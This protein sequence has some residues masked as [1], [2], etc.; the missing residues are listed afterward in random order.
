LASDITCLDSPVLSGVATVDRWLAT[1]TTA[2][3]VTDTY[4]IMCKNDVNN[5]V[6]SMVPI[7]VTRPA[8]KQYPLVTMTISKACPSGAS[9][10][11][12]APNN[13][14]ELV[15]ITRYL[16]NKDGTE[17][18]FGTNTGTFSF[19]ILTQDSLL[20]TIVPDIYV[21]Y[22]SMSGVSDARVG[23]LSWTTS[24]GTWQSVY[25][26]Q[27]STTSTSS[28]WT[29]PISIT[30]TDGTN[31]KIRISGS[32]S[33]L[34]S[35]CPLGGS[36]VIK[37]AHTPGGLFVDI[38]TSST[39][40]IES[41]GSVVFTDTSCTDCFTP[42]VTLQPPQFA[43]G[44]TPSATKWILSTAAQASSQYDYYFS[45][46]SSSAESTK[47]KVTFAKTDI[48]KKQHPR[49]SFTLS[50]PCTQG[51]KVTIYRKSLTS[52][53]ID[54]VDLA[55]LYNDDGTQFQIQGT[56]TF[57]F[58]HI[59]D[60][61]SLDIPIYAFWQY[62]L[63]QGTV[64]PYSRTS[65][66]KGTD[67]GI[68]TGALDWTLPGYKGDWA[69]TYQFRCTMG[70]TPIGTPRTFY[71]TKNGYGSPK[72]RIVGS[73]TDYN[74]KACPVGKLTVLRAKG[75]RT[76]VA[77]PGGTS[78]LPP[79]PPSGGSP[80]VGSSTIGFQDITS[81]GTNFGGRAFDNDLI[82]VDKA[83]TNAPY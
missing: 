55:Q 82:F 16:K 46:K 58:W 12:Y 63:D 24:S 8:Q 28:A 3:E 7:T 10:K 22:N 35:P 64:N 79:L 59:D 27:C 62:M 48:T 34:S 40:T 71:I 25:Q 20:S 70:S 47:V 1:S 5:L 30:K 81:Q 66:P 13:N 72:I 32:Q 17:F 41:D 61:G 29:A 14:Q 83:I 49:I 36:L 23:D 50:A 44:A 38:T 68:M 60:T 67:F 42:V 37:R 73:T 6:S 21:F 65:Y 78:G 4:Y 15:E 57:A 52:D 43:T 80:P 45:C 31:P 77:L 51:S 69:R 74:L 26:F 76:I 2:D 75:D 33:G 53:N 18:T 54:E 9:L 56:T 19:W 11:L 39:P